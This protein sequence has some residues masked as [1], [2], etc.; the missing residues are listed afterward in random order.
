MT[1]LRTTTLDREGSPAP[2]GV[3]ATRR[4]SVIGPAQIEEVTAYERPT[5]FVYELR[6]GLP[7]KELVGTRGADHIWRRDSDRLPRARDAG[8]PSSRT[9][10]RSCAQ[11]GN[12]PTSQR[13]DQ[14]RGGSAMSAIASRLWRYLHA[15]TTTKG[16][17][18]A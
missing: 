7:V 12:R 18:D 15:H 10:P 17:A 5:R 6:S 9:H 11:V 3:G 14:N 1:P 2:N 8:E 4:F 13:R 16:P